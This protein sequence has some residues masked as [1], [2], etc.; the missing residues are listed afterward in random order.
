MSVSANVLN[1][2]ISTGPIAAASC[3]AI[4]SSNRPDFCASDKVNTMEFLDGL[5]A[6][7]Y[8]KCGGHAIGLRVLWRGLTGLRY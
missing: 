7:C 1:S 3:W 2:S 8:Q 5:D 6:A 4:N